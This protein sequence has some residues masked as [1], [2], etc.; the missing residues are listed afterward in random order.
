MVVLLAAAACGEN[1]TS[2]L[3]EQP[4]FSDGEAISV[5]KQWLITAGCTAY[6]ND[7]AE[8][9]H[10]YLGGEVW[11]VVAHF[12]DGVLSRWRVYEGTTVNSHRHLRGE[13]SPDAVSQPSSLK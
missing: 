1:A 3:I 2:T 9:H 8:W 4:H 7:V 11:N 10:E 6:Y 5:V 12:T 13:Q